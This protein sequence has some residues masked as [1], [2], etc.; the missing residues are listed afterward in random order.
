M[1]LYLLAIV[2]CALVA[3]SLGNWC[4]YKSITLP[5]WF[6][7][8][9]FLAFLILGGMAGAEIYSIVQGGLCGL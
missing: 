7:F 3:A 2:S 5:N 9:L 4:L 6:R 8:L 1:G